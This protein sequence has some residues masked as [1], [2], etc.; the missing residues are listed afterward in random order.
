MTDF[1]VQNAQKEP[2]MNAHERAM[3]AAKE[4]LPKT[5]I[6]TVIDY[7]SRLLDG[8]SVKA[9]AGQIKQDYGPGVKAYFQALIET[10]IE[11][12]LNNS[13]HE[14]LQNLG[15][16]GFANVLVDSARNVFHLLQGVFRH[17]IKEE[18][19][20][21]LLSEIGIREVGMK[22]LEA[23]GID[24]D[25][26]ASNPEILMKLCSPTVAYQAS[27]AAYKEYCQAL[28]EWQLAREERLRVEK[29]CRE[30]IADIKKYRQQMEKQVSHYLNLRLDTIENSFA[31][32]DR[33]ILENDSDGYI[34]ANVEI[35]K[36]LG[37][38]VQFTNQREFDDLM[39]SDD[40]LK[41]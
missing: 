35:Q 26:A 31:A 2:G 37:Y 8:E 9:V 5:D 30:T 25:E 4:L 6:R 3:N 22:I 38:E 34:A 17:E 7:V 14:V 11:D 1:Q 33:A 27:M 12:Q 39:D 10:E 36:M 20:A 28:A 40:A 21:S 29:I 41:L 16:N 18:E 13:D 15:E 24:P 32:M 23:C 19:L